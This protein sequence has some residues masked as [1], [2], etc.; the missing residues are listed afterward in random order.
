LSSR[1]LA[2]APD[3]AVGDVEAVVRAEI[4]K[5][6]GDVAGARSGAALDLARRMDRDPTSGAPNAE[7]LRL[8][9]GELAPPL[10]SADGAQSARRGPPVG[11][12]GR[13]GLRVVTDA[14]VEVE[15]APERAEVLL[16]TLREALPHGVNR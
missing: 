1:E 11:E 13:H 7:Q 15:S 6:R 8:L 3:D 16:A 10:D 5:R 12:A 9:L 14:G 4:T 2:G